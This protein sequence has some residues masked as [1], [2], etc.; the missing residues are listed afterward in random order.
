MLVFGVIHGNEQAGLQIVH[1]LE[2]MDLPHDVDLWLVETMNPD[3]LAHDVRQ[4]ADQV[5]LNRNFPFN[6]GPLGA[7]G[8]WEY[9]GPSAASEPETQAVVQFMTDLQPDLTIWYHQDYNRISPTTGREGK[10]RAR[11]SELTGIPLL[12]ISGGTYTGTAATW[13][14]KRVPAGVAF[15]VELGTTLKP[16]DA[17]VHANAILTIADELS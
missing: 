2:T 7:P 9:A 5:D 17:L 10:V 8:D 14:R 12:T 15:I 6:W 16:A 4:N 1:L 13:A 3:G 11:Y